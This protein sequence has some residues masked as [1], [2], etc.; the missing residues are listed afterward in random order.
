[1]SYYGITNTVL[2]RKYSRSFLRQFRFGT[3]AGHD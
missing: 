2:M 1:M 3:I